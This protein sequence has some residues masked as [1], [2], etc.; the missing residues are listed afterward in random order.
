MSVAKPKTNT[1][2]NTPTTN[3]SKNLNLQDTS[4]ITVG[5]AGGDIT[6][7]NTDH[8]AFGQ[9]SELAQRSLDVG[10]DAARDAFATSEYFAKLFAEGSAYSLDAVAGF[11]ER[12]FSTT[13][14]VFA[15][16]SAYQKQALTAVQ[17]T[18]ANALDAVTGAQSDALANVT[19]VF[20]YAFDGI[21]DFIG[22]LQ[23][24]AQSQLGDTVESLNAIAVENN[25]SS[26]QRIAEISDK[27]QRY[28]VI[29]V[30]VV[31]VGGLI[32]AASRR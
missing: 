6:I 31:V 19:G 12:A 20:K 13:D 9:A 17:D 1:T 11:G 27:S 25:K 14:K 5:E 8:N 32:Y 7:V 28:V 21:T 3:T 23:E 30:A 4:G 18:Q 16:A 2:T 10:A 22:K 26:D 29:V 24:N 15:D